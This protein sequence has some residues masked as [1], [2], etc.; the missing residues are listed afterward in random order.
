MTRGT[1]EYVAQAVQSEITTTWLVEIP[2]LVAVN[3]PSTSIALYFTDHQSEILYEGK[4]FIPA[5]LR[6]TMPKISRDMERSSGKVE[7]SN[8]TSAFSGYAKNYRIQDAEIIVT[9]AILNGTAWVG[10]VSFVGTMDAPTITERQIVVGILNG[11]AVATLIPRV[12][13]WGRDFPHLP[14]SKN[15]RNI[16]VK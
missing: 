12:L 3:D 9:H 16:P 7:L 4:T 10:L 6:L 11:R 15:P 2:A 5:P 13:Y 14:S 8:L 1:V